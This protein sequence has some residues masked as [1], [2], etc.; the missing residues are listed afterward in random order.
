MN[1]LNE[2]S[3][4]QYLAGMNLRPVKDYGYYGMY[5][6]PFRKDRNASF[7]VDYRKNVWYDFGTNEGGTM[8][9]IVMRMEDCSF[10]EAADRLEDRYMYLRSNSRLSQQI[11]IT[12]SHENNVSAFSFHGD[13]AIENEPAMKIRN[14]IPIAHP[15]LTAWIR[16]RKIELGLADLY[17]MEI[18]YRNKDKDYF[19]VGFRNDKG[20]Y[21]LSCPPD[22]KGCIP[23]KE[24]TTI[25][26]NEDTC[27]VFE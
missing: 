19:S 9:D 15:K 21:E 27:L 1:R 11:A 18:H 5:H 22:F 23:P 14:I 3:I 26:S 16:E 13:K 20:G 24:I 25:R 10:H 12:T 17:C 4:K 6:C 7:K 8:I 2:I